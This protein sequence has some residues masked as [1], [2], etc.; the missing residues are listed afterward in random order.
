M[1]SAVEVMDC[2][3]RIPVTEVHQGLDHIVELTGDRDIGLKAAY[4]STPGDGT[5][6]RMAVERR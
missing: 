2:D 6:V 3:Q 5:T 1:F 4:E